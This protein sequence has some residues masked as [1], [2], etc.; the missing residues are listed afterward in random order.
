MSSMKCKFWHRL[1][2]V[3]GTPAGFL[4]MYNSR[5]LYEKVDKSEAEYFPHPSVA[6]PSEQW[7]V[8]ITWVLFFFFFHIQIPTP[9]LRT[10][11]P[12]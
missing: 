8:R 1:F 2:I 5:R 4:D 3:C 12:G 10:T 9:H 11:E 7:T 6:I